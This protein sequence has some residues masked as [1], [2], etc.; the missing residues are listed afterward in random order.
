MMKEK[1]M[2]VGKLI[3][4]ERILDRRTGKT[5]IVPLD[6]GATVGPIAGVADYK[7]TVDGISEGGA[8]A[9]LMHKGLVRAGH[10]GGGKDIGLIVHVSAST[11][12]APDPNA[13]IHVCDV[14]EA[15]MMGADAVSIHV[16]LG[17]PT[18]KEMLQEFGRIS[19]ECYGWG[20]PL[21]AMVYTRG[22]KIKN[23]YDPKLVAHAARL[24]AELGADV[25]KV[26]YTGS[27]ETFET[28]V[29]GCPVPV[30]IAGGEKTETDRELV[31]MVAGAIQ[32][33]AGGASIGRNVFQHKSPKGIVE[34]MSALVHEGASVEAAMEMLKEKGL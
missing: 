24:G 14:E 17:A 30:V 4:I 3:R 34:V 20:M 5:I 13:K 18:E 16:N 25:V 10:R 11:A 6:H 1:R 19:K 23:E 21:V 33:G 31:E 28:V 7:R 9:V 32:A 29:R 26:N 27:P 22:P 2:L 12:L 8:N 15:I